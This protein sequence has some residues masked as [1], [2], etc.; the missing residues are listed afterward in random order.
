MNGK[1]IKRTFYGF[2]A[3]GFLFVTVREYLQAGV[4][5]EAVLTASMGAVM[6][7]LAYTGK[8]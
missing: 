3:V 5:A 2:L 8:G 7:I 1:T 4:T 6:A